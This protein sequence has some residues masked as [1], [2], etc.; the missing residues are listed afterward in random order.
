MSHTSEKRWPYINEQVS[1][2]AADMMRV[3]NEAEEAYQQFQEIYAYA[4]GTLQAMAD[5]LYQDINGN[6]VP[7]TDTATPAQVDTVTDAGAAMTK[8]HELW[9]AINNVAA[10]VQEDRATALRRMI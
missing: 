3:S 8:L 10:L 5:L 6:P 9:Q 1:R 4:G 2:F 7:I